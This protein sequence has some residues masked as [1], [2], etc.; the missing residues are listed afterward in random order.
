MSISLTPRPPCDVRAGNRK[1]TNAKIRGSRAWREA[2]D[3]FLIDH[4]IC[5]YCGNPSSIV[6]HP[7]DSMYGEH[8]LDFSRCEAVCRSCHWYGHH[9]YERCSCG[10]GWHKA[11]SEYCHYCLP[12]SVREQREVRTIKI[13]KNRREADKRRR[14]SFKQWLR[15]K[16]VKI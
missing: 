9:G 14:E 16:G 11:G 8:Y 15:D 12:N 6:H 2:R 1:K 13:K 4:Q 5:V 7:E 3:L 10:Q